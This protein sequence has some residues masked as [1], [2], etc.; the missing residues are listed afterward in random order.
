VSEPQRSRKP[1]AH[2]ARHGRTWRLEHALR[3]N[4][5]R[6][7]RELWDAGNAGGTTRPFDTE[8]TITA[9]RTVRGEAA[10]E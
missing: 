3:D 6:R 1:H 5:I 8:R 9:A 10:A 7:L 4:E 2:P